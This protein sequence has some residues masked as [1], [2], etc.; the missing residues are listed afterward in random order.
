IFC[1]AVSFTVQA[2][3]YLIKYDIQAKRSNYFLVENK[4]TVKIRNIDP[5]KNR[6]I[7]L[8]VDNYNPFYW[9]ARVT[10]FK[11]PVEE[12]VGYSSAFNPFSVLAGG[13]GNIMG[14]LPKLDMP[15]SRGGGLDRDDMD[16]ATY[17]FL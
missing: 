17:Q 1:C 4:D 3:Q 5:N 2:Q 8:Q 13:L 11:T 10:A 15:A 16:A 7:V 14:S 9:N 12:E 6:R